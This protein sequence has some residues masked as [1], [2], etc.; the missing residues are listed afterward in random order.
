MSF[1]NY[2]AAQP[3]F[4]IDERPSGLL[5]TYANEIIPKKI[6]LFN[7]NLTKVYNGTE[8]NES[9]EETYASNTI[10]IVD[11]NY[12]IPTIDL[13]I[14]NATVLDQN[15]TLIANST[16]FFDCKD[17]YKTYVPINNFQSDIVPLIPE[18]NSLMTRNFDLQGNTT[19]PIII[20]MKATL[21]FYL[22]MIGVLSI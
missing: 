7:T 19:V 11:V 13:I 1:V 12:S 4:V 18:N 3:E 21:T 9:I 16:S 10:P 15:D 17:C 8:I 22:K 14:P 2:I 20:Q 6:V 5:S